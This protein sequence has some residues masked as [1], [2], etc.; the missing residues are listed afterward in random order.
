MFGYA[1]DELVSEMLSSC[2]IAL[3]LI[4]QVSPDADVKELA[5]QV[6]LSV[7]VSS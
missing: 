1:G 7:A 5:S 3:N 2:Q 4:I 6:M